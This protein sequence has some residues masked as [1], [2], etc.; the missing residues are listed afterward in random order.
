MM[1]QKSK[2]KQGEKMKTK[3]TDNEF[4]SDI[5]TISK[6]YKNGEY[7]L[8]EAKACIMAELNVYLRSL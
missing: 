8:K 4:T 3:M 5:K 2:N 7:S 6:K 1:T